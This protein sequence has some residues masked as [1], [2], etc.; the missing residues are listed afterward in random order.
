MQLHTAPNCTPLS[1]HSVTAHNC[2]SHASVPHRKSTISYRKLPHDGGVVG[3]GVDGDKVDV[4]AGGGTGVSVG[5]SVGVDT[6]VLDGVA[7]DTVC[8]TVDG[9]SIV[10]GAG[11]DTGV[12]V[13]VSV[14][15]ATA[16]VAVLGECVVTDVVDVVR[17]DVVEVSEH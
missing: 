3:A 4:G 7:V 10:V 11:G 13:G 9:S 17:V 5:V 15:V 16:V 14:G 1:G 2:P 12:S 8:A 6:C